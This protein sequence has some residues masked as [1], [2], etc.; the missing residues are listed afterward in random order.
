M[1]IGYRVLCNVLLY[2]WL[3][4][5]AHALADDDY[6]FIEKD[7]AHNYYTNTWAVHIEGGAQHAKSVAERHNFV[8]EGQVG[9]LDDIY[10]LRHHEVSKRSKR[11][12]DIHHQ[13]LESHPSVKWLEQQKILKR[14]KRGFFSDPLWENQWYLKNEGQTSSRCSSY[15]GYERLDIDV[16][17]AWNANITGNGVVVSILDDGLEYTHPDLK[18]NYDKHA[19][20]DYNSGD[21]DPFP[22]YT[23]DNI[24]KHGT[25]CAGE[26]AAEINNNI[27]GAG[28]AFN[29]K[30][31]GIRMLDG[32]VTDAV[33]AGSLSFRPEY[34]DI[35]SSSWGPDDDGKTVDGPG[36][37]AK[38]AFQD[39][40]K[41]GRKGRG[42]IFVWATGNG[43]RFE[44]YCSCDGYIN[45][46]YTISIGAVDNCGLKPWYA[47]PCPST[48]A[49]TYSSGE[50]SGR[51]DKQIATTD[52]RGGCTTTHTGTSAAAPLAAGIFALVLEANRRLTWRDLQHLVV[53]TSILVSP[54]DENWQTNGAGHKVNIRF[55]F[56]ALSAA[57]LVHLATSATWKTALPQHECSTNVK[58]TNQALKKRGKIESTITTS[59][60]ARK[61]SNCITKLEHVHV[62]IDIEKPSQRG[63]IEIQ[64]TSPSGTKSDILRKR[65]LDTDKKEGFRN[66]AF[67]TVFN[68]DENPEGT[69]KLTVS[70]HSTTGGKLNKWSL[71]FYGTCDAN[72]IGLAVN[73]SEI[74]DKECNRNCPKNF[75]DICMGCSQYCDCTIGQCVVDCGDLITDSQLRH[76]RRSEE[77]INYDFIP[78]VRQRSRDKPLM[79]ISFSATFAIICF[80]LVIISMVI[81]GIAYLAAKMPS[82][83]DAKGYQS[84]ARYP[85][86]DLVIEDCDEAA[87]S[88][89]N[90]VVKS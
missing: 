16:F 14:R 15:P 89:E 71:K 1:I 35:Y 44:D 31:G 80:S 57:K 82:K 39:G 12:A 11:S 43:G 56:G 10:H 84:V 41:K 52:L 77:E 78:H 54:K 6:T 53:L 83:K 3:W 59:G 29:A 37:L 58:N 32:D 42:S 17:P 76:C 73:E 46:P 64:L 34:I 47:E 26:V 88:D 87:L 60:C 27:C 86:S 65:V 22:R 7:R 13:L 55:G 24:N 72:S 81:G 19:S 66:W 4:L 20:Y 75:S 69:W 62:I 25:R 33:E 30:V 18:K 50:S 2:V 85:C 63:M 21:N 38:K 67:L 9:S 40:I 74:C 79:G 5:S 36:R 48:F 45:S 51:L 90:Y 49:V 61:P 28:V 23:N 70:D 8:F 68:W